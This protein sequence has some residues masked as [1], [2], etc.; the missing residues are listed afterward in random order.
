MTWQVPNSS[1]ECPD[2]LQFP[3]R[4]SN[5]LELMKFSRLDIS[6]PVKCAKLSSEIV[7][8]E[9]SWAKWWV[10]EVKVQRPPLVGKQKDHGNVPVFCHLLR[11]GHSQNTGRWKARCQVVKLSSIHSI[12]CLGTSSQCRS[13][14]RA[15]DCAATLRHFLEERHFRVPE[16]S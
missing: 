10:N 8:A 6:R 11:S 1:C 15:D 9:N 3:G 13:T 7:M 5:H 4:T 16:S 2:C 14:S 12:P